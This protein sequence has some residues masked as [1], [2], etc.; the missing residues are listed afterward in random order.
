MQTADPVPPLDASALAFFL[1]CWCGY[2]IVV[3]RAQ[4]PGTGL[5]ATMHKN[6][7]A[8]MRQ[9]AMRE[10]RIVDTS[11]VN[12]LCNGSAFFASTSL[13]AIGGAATLLRATDDALR[14][15]ADLPLVPSF[16]RG[17][18]EIKAVGLL[19]IFGY[20]FFK[21]AWSYRLFNYA[22]ILV[23]ATPLPNAPDTAARLAAADRAAEMTVVAGSN[24][25]AGQRAFFFSFAYLGWFLGPLVLIG[26]TLLIAVVVWRRQFR[27]DALDALTVGSIDE[28][29][30]R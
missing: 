10:N 19:V 21:F 20:A 16:S 25:A 14:L 6:R 30:M 12:T 8:W 1:V 13:I 5:M 29:A 28:G 15:F 24:F 4:S 3:R 27:S 11:I 23:G 9:M 26:A 2:A 18:W 7:I 22:A 17:M